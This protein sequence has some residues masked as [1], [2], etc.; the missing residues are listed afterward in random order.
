MNSRIRNRI[1][2]IVGVTILSIALFA[3]FPPSLAKMRQ[4]VHL[5]LDLR[6][7]MHLV[8]QVVTDDAIRAETDQAID[9]LRQQLAKE[10]IVFR[11]L[12]RT[13]NNTLQAV[14]VDANK[15]ADFR[16]SLNER[17]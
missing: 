17:F 3:G 4:K 8:L 15:D 9:N 12:T 10:N 5:G 14:G 11:Q 7:G 13:Q 1:L 6:G 2:V 16:R